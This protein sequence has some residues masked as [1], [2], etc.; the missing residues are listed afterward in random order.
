[1]PEKLNS[2]SFGYDQSNELAILKMQESYKH[3]IPNVL[4]RSENSLW[5]SRSLIVGLPSRM[6]TIKHPLMRLS[7]ELS[8]QFKDLNSTAA[9]SH[10]REPVPTLVA[11]LHQV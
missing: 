6:L 3:V 11:V 1:M 5:N 10:P 7:K 9:L 2:I 4:I 8:F